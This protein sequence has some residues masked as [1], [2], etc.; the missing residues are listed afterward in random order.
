MHKLERGDRN[1]GNM[2]E[3]AETLLVKRG[4]WV[5]KAVPRG[6]EAAAA[7][8]VTAATSPET[9]EIGEEDEQWMLEHDID[10]GEGGEDSAV[11]QR[12]RLAVD[13]LFVL[14][15]AKSV[16]SSFVVLQDAHGDG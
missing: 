7:A 12:R 11:P 4:P 15:M 14:L 5:K 8:T 16:C 1:D 9:V 13:S 3:T 10:V 2:G 6:H